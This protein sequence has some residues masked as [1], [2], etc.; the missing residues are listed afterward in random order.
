LVVDF[1]QQMMPHIDGAADLLGRANILIRGAK[2][3]G[4][5]IWATEQ[6]PKGL[7]PTVDPIREALG[8]DVELQPK[9]RFSALIQP[10]VEQLAESGARTVLLCGVETH[11]C[12]LQTALDLADSGFIPVT[13]ADA[14]G[15]RRAMDRQVA[16]E[17]LGSVGIISSVE[18]VLLEMVQDAAEEPFK[19][20]LPWIK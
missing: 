5:P 7:G 16:L 3:L 13:V 15:S 14:V 9:T 11:V 19:A 12:I 10:I 17:R 6:Y 18:S 1:Q 8:S 2:I 20:I 4:L